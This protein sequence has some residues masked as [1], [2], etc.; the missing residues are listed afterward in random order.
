VNCVESIGEYTLLS[1]ASDRTLKL[2]D[3]HSGQCIK[4]IKLAWIPLD[5]ACEPGNPNYI[6]TANANGTLT[7]F[8]LSD[9]LNPG[10][11][12]RGK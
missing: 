10:A 12:D 9:I 11:P 1:G 4:T 6:V 3:I 5:I 2:W 7:F 8:D